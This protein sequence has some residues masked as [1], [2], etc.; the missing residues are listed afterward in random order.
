MRQAVLSKK[1]TREISI[2]RN[3]DSFTK[4]TLY[5]TKAEKRCIAESIRFGRPW[6]SA[7]NTKQV[8][9]GSVANV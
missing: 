2:C 1:E 5:V 9:A 4:K 3:D 6:P 7:R 8:F